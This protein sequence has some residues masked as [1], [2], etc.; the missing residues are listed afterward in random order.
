MEKALG[1]AG[2][3]F[4]RVWADE[5]ESVALQPNT[6]DPVKGGHSAAAAL[7]RWSSSED[8]GN[9]RLDKSAKNQLNIRA[10]LQATR[11]ATLV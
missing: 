5:A 3:S 2:M 10:L 11:S 6:L 1:P 8:C 7:V 9:Y 4:R